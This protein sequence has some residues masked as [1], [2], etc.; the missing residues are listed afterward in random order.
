[1]SQ[2]ILQY[3][4]RVWSTADVLV[5]AGIKQSDFPEYMMP[6]FAMIML[7]RDNLNNLPIVHNYC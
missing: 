6:Y 4:S 7:D 2:N 1:M 3:E 5:G